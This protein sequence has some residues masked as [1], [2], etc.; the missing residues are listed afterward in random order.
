MCFCFESVYSTVVGKIGETNTGRKINCHWGN[1]PDA[2]LYSC[3][4]NVLHMT[5][6][7]EVVFVLLQSTFEVG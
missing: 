3:T 5:T 4:I 7:V 1:M 2:V 6:L